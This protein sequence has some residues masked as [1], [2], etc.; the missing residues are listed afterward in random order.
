MFDRATLKQQS[1]S[2][3]VFLPM[4]PTILMLLPRASASIQILHPGL[5]AV[6]WMHARK[7]VAQRI[8]REILGVYMFSVLVLI[9]L[10][11]VVVHSWYSLVRYRVHCYLNVCIKCPQERSNTQQDGGRNR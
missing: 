10:C 4:L 8:D 7:S 2:L 5:D 1:S 9:K 11:F 3:D 6:S